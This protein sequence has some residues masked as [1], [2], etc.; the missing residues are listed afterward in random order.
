MAKL[1]AE[2]IAAVKGRGFLINRGTDCF[3]GRIVAPGTVF[4]AEDFEN[5]AALSAKY[6]SGKLLC[7]SRMAV[8]I[9]GI[10]FENIPGSG[11]LC[12]SARPALWGTGAKVR[13]VTACKGTTC[14]YGNYD[15]QALAREIHE[16]FYLGWSD[17]KLPHKFKI[18]VGGCPIAALSRR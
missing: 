8:E 14:V 7:T 10:S 2:D 16:K 11:G 6:G 4:T 15:T 9:P 18:A 5:I 12:R 1:K 13:P 17:V 3:S